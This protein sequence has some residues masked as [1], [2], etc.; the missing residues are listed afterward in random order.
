MWRFRR[1]GGGGTATAEPPPEMGIEW[2]GTTAELWGEIERLSAAN[3]EQPDRDVERR[4]LRLR[5]LAGI[6]ATV[7]SV[8]DPRVRV[9]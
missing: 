2:E 5:H 4:V 8:T 1:K 3:R 7:A 9:R 6:A